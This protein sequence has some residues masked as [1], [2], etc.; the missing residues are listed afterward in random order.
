MYLHE[1]PMDTTAHRLCTHIS[2]Q[3]L[4]MDSIVDAC[5]DALLIEA[6]LATRKCFLM[7]PFKEV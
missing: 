5:Q 7:N 1:I 6:I 2:A 4:Q 3:A